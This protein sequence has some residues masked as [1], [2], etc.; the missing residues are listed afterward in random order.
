MADLSDVEKSL[1]ALIANIIFAAPYSSGD[2]QNSRV[3]APWPPATLANPTPSLVP[4]S[5]KLYRGWPEEAALD[6]D[7]ALGKAHV[8]V[9]P[10]DGMSRLIDRYFSVFSPVLPL[11]AA[12]LAWSV[13]G[14]VA[15]L[16]GT[17]T[18]PQNLGI[19]VDGLGFAYGVQATDT[20]AT[21]A[22]GLTAL[23]AA[24][25]TA[26]SSGAAITIPNSHSI[27]ARIGVVGSAAAEV[28]RMQQG[29][30]VSVWTAS[31]YARDALSSA[32]DKGLAGLLDPVSGLPTQRFLLSDGS[33]AYMTYRATY[34]NDMPTKDRVWRRDLCYMIEY[35]EFAYT[36]AP[37]LIVPVENYNTGITIS[38]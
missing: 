11:P 12:T 13:S 35:A 8:S 24:R 19:I 27:T 29:I 33:T 4:I 34:I 6:A 20:L 31:A 28:R 23:I 16:S 38:V 2:F 9:F 18:T 5:T 37:Q 10:E 7:L 22:A 17:I 14:N 36:A 3:L 30:R 21:A 1:V 32:V 25:R 26:T 15:T